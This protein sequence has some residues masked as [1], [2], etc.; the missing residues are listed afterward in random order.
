MKRETLADGVYRT[1][2]QQIV[3]GGLLPGDALYESNLS[4]ELSVSRTPI[5][6]A[7]RRL[8]QEGL[9]EIEPRRGAR[10]TQVSREDVFSAFEI[11]KWLEPSIFAKAAVTMTDEQ[12]AVL[13][14]VVDGMPDSPATK[15]EISAAVRADL[16]FHEIVANSVDNKYV[17]LLFS[18]LLVVTRRATHFTPPVRRFRRSREEHSMIVDALEAHDPEAAARAARRHMRNSYLAF[19]GLEEDS[20]YGEMTSN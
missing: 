4:T 6:E 20:E 15:K 16:Q 13:R 19:L 3:T 5:R 7:F 1:L 10:V 8:E 14:E 9:I 18:S 11:R 12:I 2:R 17:S